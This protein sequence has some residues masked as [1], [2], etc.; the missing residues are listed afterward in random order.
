MDNKTA[1]V[2]VGPACCSPWARPTYPFA[3][4]DQ[5]L[6]ASQ[7]LL[8]LHHS[9][10]SKPTHSFSMLDSTS[11]PRT[12]DL[13]NL[14]HALQ[15]E[16]PHASST[17][18]VLQAPKISQDPLGPLCSTQSKSSHTASSPYTLP[19][20]SPMTQGG[21]LAHETIG[22]QQFV[23]CSFQALKPVLYTPPGILSDSN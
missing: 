19:A 7:D 11:A 5:A 17:P 18:P 21:Q 15:S 16:P 1:Q 10:Q 12:R 9:L 20:S 6:K 2:L 4:P 23:Y 13:L 8:G 22:H 3:A 14:D